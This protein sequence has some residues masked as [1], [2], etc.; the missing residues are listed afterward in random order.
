VCVQYTRNAS[1]HRLHA[2]RSNRTTYG[3]PVAC[4]QVLVVRMRDYQRSADPLACRL[5]MSVDGTVVSGFAPA[6]DNGVV[7]MAGSVDHEQEHN[8][9]PAAARC[10]LMLANW[11]ILHG[12]APRSRPLSTARMLAGERGDEL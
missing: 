4:L 7:R 9:A 8:G 3:P 11:P 1:W 5:T 12:S 2:E 6:G 10:V